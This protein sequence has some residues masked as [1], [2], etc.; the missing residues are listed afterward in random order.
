MSQ[1]CDALLVALVKQAISD[2]DWQWFEG[3]GD[4]P[5]GF[6]WWVSVYGYDPELILEHAD[7]VLRDRF[8][9]KAKQ[10]RLPLG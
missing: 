3:D 4:D 2:N 8:C 6:I 5:F 10:P 7:P 1:Q 9:A